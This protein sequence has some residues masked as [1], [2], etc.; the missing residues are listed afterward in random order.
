MC[1]Y[2]HVYTHISIYSIRHDMTYATTCYRTQQNNKSN[3]K[4]KQTKHTNT[5]IDGWVFPRHSATFMRSVRETD[6]NTTTTYI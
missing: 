4:H 5:T 3:N 2:V 1:M 6:T